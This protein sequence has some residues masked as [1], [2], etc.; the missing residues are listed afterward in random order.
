MK[1]F[2][3]IIVAVGLI[4]L[5]CDNETTLQ[6][7]YVQ[8]QDNNQFMALDIPASLLSADVAELDAEQKA[9]L[10]TIRKV[11]LMAYPMNDK[12]KATYDQE[13]EKLAEILQ[14]EKYKTLIKY[15]GGT[16]KAELYYLGEEDAIDE[17]I[18]FGSD[19]EKGFAVARILGNNMEPAALIKLVKSFNKGDLNLQGLEALSTFKN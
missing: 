4:F 18:V 17:F 16:R 7:Y 3:V 11:N 1:T 2:K 19:E 6:E 14:A 8:N 10:E 12:N 13:R 5:S 15:G 9:T